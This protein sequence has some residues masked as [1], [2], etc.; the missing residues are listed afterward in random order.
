M[1]HDPCLAGNVTAT[2]KQQ[3][4]E[5]CAQSEVTETHYIITLE[6]EETTPR[7]ESHGKVDGALKSRHDE[8]PSW[9][10]AT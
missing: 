9:T 8:A 2:N 7:G 6:Q 3:C 10:P 5:T 4:C 1:S